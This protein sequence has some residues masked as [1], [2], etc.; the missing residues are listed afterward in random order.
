MVRKLGSFITKN[1]ILL[2][3]VG[4]LAGILFEG[5][6]RVFFPYLMVAVLGVMYLSFLKMD[7]DIMKAEFSNWQRQSILCIGS[8]MVVPCVIFYAFQYISEVFNLGPSYS[9]GALLLFAAPTAALS[10]TLTLMVNGLFERT[11]LA[12]ILTSLL[13]PLTLPLVLY[14]TLGNVA[15]LNLFE[16]MKTLCFMIVIPF[17][18]AFITR[19]FLKP[20]REKVDMVVAPLSV[21]LLIIIELASLHGLREQIIEKFSEILLIGFLGQVVFFMTFIIGWNSER[22]AS[23]SVKITNSIIFT[24]GNLGL[25]IGIGNQFF[26]ESMP[27]VP[28]FLT[29]MVIPWYCSI[30]LVKKFAKKI[31]TK[32]DLLST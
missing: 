28:L 13:A 18:L 21:I 7:V 12:M 11:L 26:R 15:D 31:E 27:E 20:S 14:L 24:W 16:I 29:V 25:A 17:C 6:T 5:L 8:L 22:G 9:V 1:F 19:K 10:T 23:S 30:I 32:N 3:I 2:I 4:F